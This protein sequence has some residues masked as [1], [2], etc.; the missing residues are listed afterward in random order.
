MSYKLVVSPTRTK[1]K[2][3]STRTSEFEGLLQILGTNFSVI[4]VLLVGACLQTVIVLTVRD[5]RY[6]L[7]PAFIALSWRLINSILIAYNVKANPYMK[8]VFLGRASTIVPDQEGTIDSDKRQQVVILL[9]GAKTN[10]AFGIFGGQFNQVFNWLK[11]MNNQFDSENA[12]EG[13]L[14][15]TSYNRK[16]ERGALEFSIISYW[17]SIEDLHA[18]AHSPLHR[19]AWLWWEKTLKQNDCVGIN[20]EIF[21]APAGHWENIYANFQPTGLGSI[22]VLRKGDKLEGGVID[23][24]WIT[25]LVDIR[26]GKLSKSSARLGRDP[27]KYDVDRPSGEMYG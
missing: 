22:S 26:K 4:T 7:L 21:E 23:D 9:L 18:Y 27:T 20:H 2:T 6:A 3:Q 11:K 1:P 24:E 10:H 16:D 14:G 25:P 12:P 5:Y 8:D 19:E 17:R 15:Q 13:F